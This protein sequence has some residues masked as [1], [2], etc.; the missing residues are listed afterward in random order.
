MA[1]AGLGRNLS[2]IHLWMDDFWTVYFLT[3]FL[4]MDNSVKTVEKKSGG[5]LLRSLLSQPF[6]HY[7]RP[8]VLFL[9][10]L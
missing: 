7:S 3:A 8:M 1:G 10:L 4:D 6:L 5:W 9:P 2:E